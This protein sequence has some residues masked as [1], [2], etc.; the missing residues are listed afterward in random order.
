MFISPIVPCSEKTQSMIVLGT[1]VHFE[2]QQ[3]TLTPFNVLKRHFSEILDV[4]YDAN[5]LANDL[6][7]VDLIS[8]VV[9]D[10]IITT[11]SVPRYEKASKLLNEFHK[12]LKTSKNP[13]ALILLCKVLT[14]Q[15][16]PAILMICNTML[17]ELGK[18]IKYTNFIF[19]VIV[20]FTL[21]YHYIH[22]GVSLDDLPSEVMSDTDR[23]VVKLCDQYLQTPVVHHDM[24]NRRVGGDKF[25]RLGLIKGQGG[26]NTMEQEMLRS[27]NMLRGN[28][29]SIM[30]TSTKI[31]IKDVLKHNDDNSPVKVVVDGPSGVGK[32]TLCQKLCNM[33]AKNELKECSI[34][35]V[36][37]LPLRDDRITS[38][39]NIY[40]LVSLF[41]S[42]ETVCESVSRHIK[43]TNGKGVLLMFHEW[44]EFEGRNRDRSFILDI[45]RGIYL[46]E[47]TILVTSRTYASTSLLE[48]RH[49]NRHVEVLGFNKYE[50]FSCIENE[51][52]E[53]NAKD[54]I[55]KLKTR[56][57]VLSM[58]YIPFVCS[59]LVIVYHLCDC[60]L[61]NTLTE[62]YMKYVLYAINRSMKKQELNPDTVE[63]L[64]E[65]QEVQKIAFDELCCCAYKNLQ[66][67]N[68]TFNR[69]K[70]RN[71]PHS[72][73]CDHF[74]LIN[75]YNI[76]DTTKYQFL[77]LTIQEFL[78]AWWISQQ[79]DHSK[80]F[81]EHYQD[82]H[83]RM[84]LRFVAGLTE[85]K[86]ENYQKYFSKEVD[87]QCIKKPLFGFVSHQCPVYH[88]NPQMLCKQ[89]F[90]MDIKHL[91]FG[92]DSIFSKYPLHERYDTGTIRLLHLIYESQNK[93]LC[94]IFASSIKNS[95]LCAHTLNSS[96]F[97]L[98]C[99]YFFLKNSRKTWN[100]LELEYGDAFKS[101]KVFDEVSDMC[102]CTIK[103]AVYCDITSVIKIHQSSLCQYLQESYIK[104][105]NPSGSDAVHPAIMFTE[106]FKLPQLRILH[107]DFQQIFGFSIDDIDDE[108][109]LEMV[110][111]IS[112]N[113]NVTELLIK[114]V[115]VPKC[116]TLINCLLKG[117]KRNET[118]VSFSLSVNTSFPFASIEG[119]LI[120][121]H[122]LKAV[123]LN[124]AL[125]GML[126]S[127]CTLPGIESLTALDLGNSTIHY[128]KRYQAKKSKTWSS[129]VENVGRNV[130]NL[131]S[132]VLYKPLQI[133]LTACF[134][135]NPFLQHLGIRLDQEE[136][137][138]ELFNILCSNTTIT[139]LKIVCT[140]HKSEQVTVFHY[141]VGK[142]LQLMLSSNKTLQ[143]LEIKTKDLVLPVKYLTAGL[144]EN[145]TLQELALDFKPLE[146]DTL[147]ELF[148]AINLKSLAVIFPPTFFKEDEILP[149]V[150][151]ML[152]RNEDMNTLKVIF[153]LHFN[154][155][156]QAVAHQSFWETVLLHPSLTYICISEGILPAIVE[157]TQL[158]I[159]REQKKLGPPP[160]VEMKRKCG[161]YLRPSL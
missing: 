16:N 96:Q 109:F 76:A 154:Q 135:S 9:K 39:E 58:C 14:K 149:D 102:N 13:E 113:Y 156:I 97:D 69:N 78:A 68:S 73:K 99:L 133:P 8:N 24:L 130:T 29:D 48:M 83:F 10:D 136:N 106:L 50:I 66:T 27:W 41:H 63:S 4:V 89:I 105:L 157:K 31:D 80:L 33:W 72:S 28:V 11:P 93:H 35:L 67:H 25:G 126:P 143:C 34:D 38:A 114:L 22:I 21:V 81:G 77:H 145:N 2:S 86:D 56:V 142:S 122:T 148:E 7:A 91:R 64:E 100:Y 85:L 15:R 36:L 82:I 129:G 51:L 141:E 115:N 19:I 117:V 147:K 132:L 55:T 23:F 49:I 94:E 59:M 128:T 57:D 146:S 159:A 43:E 140:L 137:F 26:H 104:I 62:F 120:T 150:A 6:W 87:L 1:Q 44:D 5:R 151:N 92:M 17:N 144:R 3:L 131:K 46:D 45:I 155:Y 108:Q 95:S 116:K 118:I 119:L 110:D 121:N 160:I 30:E 138:E 158:M 32:T 101:V 152:Q 37:L 103:R 90:E 107:V 134:E 40:D 161:H 98:L 12:S 71:L 127:L 112:G 70:M 54:L 79:D 47:C 75:C 88:Q 53:E 74:G 61:P 153:R 42:N 125:N 124:L 52:T 139:S 123:K 65:L 84:T 111:A 20:I 60:T 18:L